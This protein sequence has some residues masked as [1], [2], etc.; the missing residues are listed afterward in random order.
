MTKS[1][2]RIADLYHLSHRPFGAREIGIKMED[3]VGQHASHEKDLSPSAQDE[4][5]PEDGIDNESDEHSSLSTSLTSLSWVIL[6]SSLL[7][8]EMQVA[9]DTTM[10]ANLQPTII[11]TRG[12]I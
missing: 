1:L 4:I 8:A 11:E 3:G 6:C 10:T 2:A 9:L 7:L 5:I 12:E